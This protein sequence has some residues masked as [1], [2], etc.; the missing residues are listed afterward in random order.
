MENT[1]NGY[2]AVNP[3]LVTNINDLISGRTLQ[4]ARSPFFR[5][6]SPAFAALMMGVDSVEPSLDGDTLAITSLALSDGDVMLTLGAEADD[7]LAGTV[8]VSNGK[9]SATLVVRYAD[10]LDGEWHSVE[11]PFEKEIQ[12][13]AV[14]ETLRFSL[15]DLGLD[16]SKGFFKVELKQ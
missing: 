7:P 12:D 8:F 10:S 6:T 2:I 15:S 4:T 14:S 1:Y 9:V 11:V 13:G 3:G 16:A 5:S